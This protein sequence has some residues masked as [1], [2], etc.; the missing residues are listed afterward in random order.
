MKL[1]H[2]KNKKEDKNIIKLVL[3]KAS[4]N[5]EHQTTNSLLLASANG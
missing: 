4:I 1:E 2:F 3:A 5:K